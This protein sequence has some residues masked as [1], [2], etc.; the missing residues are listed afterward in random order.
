MKNILETRDLCKYY[1]TGENQVRAIDHTNL[2]IC[3]G[4]FVAIVGKSGSGK[5]TLLHM[6]GGLDH[7][8]CGHVLIGGRD[9]SSL[10]D[11]ELAVFRRRK[12]G[13]IF[14][15]FNLIPS[16]NVWE[17]M[18]LPVG[19]DGQSIDEDFAEEV[20]RMLGLEEKLESLP[21]TLSGGQQQRVAIA[22]AMI[23]KPD[24]ILA[25]VN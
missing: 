16:L 14:Q 3:Q 23:S 25:D 24:I 1:G 8:T 9:I 10:K 5:S 15:A 19:L 21:N 12:I 7:P 22:R 4:E 17:N 11:E 6:L 20:V 18:V 13:F 2:S